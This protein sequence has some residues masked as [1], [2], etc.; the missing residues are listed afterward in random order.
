[1]SRRCDFVG[2]KPQ[3]GNNVSHA[4]NKTRRR[5]LPNLQ[6]ATLH[7]DILQEGVRVRLSTR[8][9]RTI[10]KNGGLDS[11]LMGTPE[12]QAWP[13]RPGHQEAAGKG[14]GCRGLSCRCV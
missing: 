3:C 10:E 6:N 12:P 7:S 9:I 8:A 4:M 2:R 11:F 1:M 5:W 14:A 13:G